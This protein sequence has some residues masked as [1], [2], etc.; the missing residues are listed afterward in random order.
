MLLAVGFIAHAHVKRTCE[1]SP[2]WCGN[3]IDNNILA[4][5]KK[6][7]YT[8]QIA[9]RHR[10]ALATPHCTRPSRTAWLWSSWR[11][12][13]TWPP[14]LG[15]LTWSDHLKIPARFFNCLPHA[16]LAVRQKNTST[17][18]GGTAFYLNY[19]GKNGPSQVLWDL[20]PSGPLS[21]MV[22]IRFWTT[23]MLDERTWT[24]GVAFLLTS[25]LSFRYSPVESSSGTWNPKTVEPK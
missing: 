5:R 11:W 9:I 24:A 22:F 14:T 1:Y 13:S 15:G 23:R 21:P 17:T 25:F 3:I 10:T 18:M 6:E 2:A 8:M 7:L 20:F 19:S 4:K 16:T 12:R